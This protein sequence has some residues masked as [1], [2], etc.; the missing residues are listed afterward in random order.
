MINIIIPHFQTFSLLSKKRLS[1]ILWSKAVEL[2]KKGDHKTEHGFI[3][4]LSIYAAIGRGSSNKVKNHFPTIVPAVL[5]DYDLKDVALEPWWLSGY[6]TIYCHFELNVLVEGWKL[7]MYYKLRH[8]FSFSRNIAELSLL[9]LIAEYLNAKTYVRSDGS[10][11][12][13]NIASLD[14]CEYLIKHFFEKFPIQSSK[15]QE[16]LI[17]RDF[18]IRAKRLNQS[19]S[20]IR[21]DNNISNFHKLVD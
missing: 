9:N 1:F 12:D 4:I 11:V 2:L 6:L 17:W 5:P 19:K 20:L 8:T 13:V 21:L 14:S 15:H 10:R 3:E 7:E 18:V 16:Y